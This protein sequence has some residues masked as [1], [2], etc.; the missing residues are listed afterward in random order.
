MKARI[1]AAALA[2]MALEAGAAP[3]RFD[4]ADLAAQARALSQSPYRAMPS[5]VPQWLR[6]LTYDQYREIRFRPTQ[7]LW[8]RDPYPFKIQFFHPGSIYD[9]AV[10]VFEL[11]PDGPKPI[12]FST[13]LF[14]YGRNKMGPIPPDLGFAGFRIHNSLNTPGDELG[15]F[16][17]ASYFRFLCV[18][19]VYGMSARGLAIN[20]AGVGPEEFPLFEKFWIQRPSGPQATEIVVYAL[21]DSPSA[22][23]A[24]EFKV[25]P[26]ADTV[27]RI[28]ATLFCRANPPIFG[29]APLTS[30][31]W[32]GKTSNFET[33]DIR[34][35]VHDSDGLMI[36]NGSDEWLWRPLDNPKGTRVMSFMDDEPRGFG[37]MQRERR[38]EA[39]QDIEAVYQLRP[40]AW[41]EPVNRWGRGEVRLV[42]LHTP[43]EFNDNIAA[44]WVP[45][46]L[47]PPGQPI[48]LE[49]N[50]HW[51]L[52]QIR[53]PMGYAVATRHGHPPGKEGK[54]EQ[55]VVDFDGLGLQKLGPGQPVVPVVSVGDGAR[56]LNAH[57]E[58]NPYNGTWRVGFSIEPDKGTEPVEVRCFLKRR[59]ELLTETW[60]YLWER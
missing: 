6:E 8:N 27:M 45:A 50:L 4:F 18:R 59:G 51:V 16:E 12:P 13:K 49:Y 1:V 15:V 26:G 36:H 48:D 56:L 34:P 39:Y 57:A 28:R 17:G 32:H 29:I 55:F 20:C 9:Q 43:T 35:E 52:D 54:E 2:T 19:A 24:Y 22:S 25:Q 42:E 47:P 5:K 38:F 33:D 23:G 30:M 14:T 10:D 60:T 41:V 53:P 7:S 21:L 3:P 31:F 44:F 58:K 40:S 37:L 11:D 46:E